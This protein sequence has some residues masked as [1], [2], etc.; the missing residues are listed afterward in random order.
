MYNPTIASLLGSNSGRR[1]V[2]IP[3]ATGLDRLGGQHPL[4]H[5]DVY[6]QVP[7]EGADAPMGT[8]RWRRRAA[9]G[10]LR[11]RTAASYF[12]FCPP[13][14]V[15]QARQPF[16]CEPSPP[17]DNHGLGYLQP[18]LDWLVA[19][20]K[21]IRARKTSRW[22]AEGERNH[23]VLLVW[24]DL[25]IAGWKRKPSIILFCISIVAASGL[26]TIMLDR[27]KPEVLRLLRP[28]SERIEL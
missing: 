20:P 13:W 5:P 16:G 24:T 2:P 9:G 22:A 28:P 27:F 7:G 6:A 1:S 3:E 25:W 19:L 4:D 10:A 12:R 11:W 21:T 14:L 17:Q 15:D 23:G 26:Y 8:H 18:L